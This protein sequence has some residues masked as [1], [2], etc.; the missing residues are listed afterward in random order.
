[1]AAGVTGHN[2]VALV[3]SEW[4]GATAPVA[5]LAGFQDCRASRMV[6]AFGLLEKSNE[7]GDFGLIFDFDVGTHSYSEV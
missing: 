5:A 4:Y 3:V 7:D 2:R 1:M 6:V